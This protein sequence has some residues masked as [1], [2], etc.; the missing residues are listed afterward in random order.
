[1]TVVFVVLV[2]VV[3]IAAAVWAYNVARIG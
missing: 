3:A 2:I 1:M